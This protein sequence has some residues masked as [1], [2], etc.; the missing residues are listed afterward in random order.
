MQEYRRAIELDPK[1]AWPHNNLGIILHD[2]GQLEEAIQEFRRAIHLDPKFALPHNNLAIALRDK[3]QMDTAI[4]ELGR[5]IELDPKYA[6]PHYNLGCALHDR[7]QLDAAIVE[8]RRAIALDPTYAQPHLSLGTTLLDLGRFTEARESYCRFR[9]LLPPDDPLRPR[10]SQ[11]LLECEQGL[12]LDQKLA[13]VREGKEKP[14]DEAQCIALAAFCQQPYQQRYVES[15]RFF[16]QAFAHNAK[17][18][19]DMQQQ[20]RY[21]AAC[22]AALAGCGQG[23]DVDKLDAKERTHLRQQAVTWLSAD[24]KHWTKQAQSVKPSDRALVQ[25]TL[26]HWQYD[27]DLAGLRDSAALKKLPADERAACQKLWADVAALLKKAGGE[28]K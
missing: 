27:P 22:S 8:F 14:A 5:A 7:H 18:A 28:T 12:A 15:Y 21:N 11:R 20:N 19:D 24:L 17:L 6:T 4:Q 1:Y 23:K 16:T 2:R 25:Q 9:D 10:A 3:G 26:Q 13:A